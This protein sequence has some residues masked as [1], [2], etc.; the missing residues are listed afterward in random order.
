MRAVFKDYLR[1]FQAW[2]L[3]EYSSR[4]KKKPAGTGGNPASAGVM[5]RMALYLKVELRLAGIR[6]WR[7]VDQVGDL[8]VVLLLRGRW[9]S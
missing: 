8:R 4:K 1:L 7:R 3:P 6:E 5:I 2:V 9:V